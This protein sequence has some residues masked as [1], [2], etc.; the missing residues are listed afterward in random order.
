MIIEKGKNSLNI[1]LVSKATITLS[2][3]TRTHRIR[4]DISAQLVPA[5]LP[6]CKLDI[7]MQGKQTPIICTDEKEKQRIYVQLVIWLLSPAG[8]FLSPA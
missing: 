3:K 2:R 4:L 5:G 1:A 8:R 7:R 6:I